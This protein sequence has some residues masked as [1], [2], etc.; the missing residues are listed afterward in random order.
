MTDE[1][2]VAEADRALLGRSRGPEGRLRAGPDTHLSRYDY[3]VAVISS[4]EFAAKH[5][6]PTPR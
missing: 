5:L 2:F 4:D 3:I 6:L 1:A